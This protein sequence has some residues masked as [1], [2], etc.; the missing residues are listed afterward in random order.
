MH[1]AILIG[2]LNSALAASSSPDPGFM[3]GL[4]S[5]DVKYNAG[6][7]PI[8]IDIGREPPLETAWR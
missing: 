2:C 3:I 1:W 6:G 5:D 4:L 8:L 7:V